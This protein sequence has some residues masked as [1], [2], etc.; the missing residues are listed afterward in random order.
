M[1]ES[2]NATLKRETSPAHTADPTRPPYAG[3]SPRG[4]P[5]T[6]PA[7]DTSTCGHRSPIAYET[8][9]YAATLTLAAW[10]HP[11]VHHQGSGPSFLD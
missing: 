7:A 4:S 9:D 6:T 2:L 3:K 1:T 10:S 5:A 8:A 11:R